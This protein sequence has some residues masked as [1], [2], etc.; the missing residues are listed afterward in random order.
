MRRTIES[1]TVE[2]TREI[3]GERLAKLRCDNNLTQKGLAK[4]VGVTR[5]AVC[6]WERG[7]S[8]P[9][10]LHLVRLAD[11][12]KCSMEY[13]VLGLDN[14]GRDDVEDQIGPVLLNRILNITEKAGVKTPVFLYVCTLWLPKFVVRF[15]Y[16]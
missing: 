12:Y 4:L 8:W 16:K 15:K 3:V 13:L 7:I 10:A 6:K 11:L 14:Q 1:Q 9:N 5:Q 2:V